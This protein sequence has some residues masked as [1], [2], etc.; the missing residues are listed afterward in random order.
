MSVGIDETDGT[1]KGIDET[2]GLLLR[3]GDVDGYCVLVTA[4]V[5]CSMLDNV[6]LLCLCIL[7]GLAGVCG[8]ISKL[9]NEVENFESS[10]P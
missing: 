4:T 1:Y 10:Q 7:N 8:D 9:S 6:L 5:I 3:L 2:L